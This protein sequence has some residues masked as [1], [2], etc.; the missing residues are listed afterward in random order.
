[1]RSVFVLDAS[2]VVRFKWVAP[3]QATEPDY[4]AVEAAVKALAH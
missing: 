1:M 2:G 3:A 4:A